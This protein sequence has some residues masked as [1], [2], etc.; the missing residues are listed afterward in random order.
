MQS[1]SVQ[2]KVERQVY[3]F[4]AFLNRLNE[5][6]DQFIEYSVEFIMIFLTNEVQEKPKMILSWQ[7]EHW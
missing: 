6:F 1:A 5:E 4:L 7:S 3:S 2:N